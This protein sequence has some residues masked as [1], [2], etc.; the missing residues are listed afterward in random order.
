MIGPAVTH[1]VESTVFAT[2]AALLLRALRVRKPSVRHAAWLLAAIK[3]A[4]PA[5][6]FT[7]LGGNI[8]AL[9]PQ[10][11]PIAWSGSAVLLAHVSTLPAAATVVILSSEKPPLEA[12]LLS[13]WLAGAIFATGVWLRRWSGRPFQTVSAPAAEAAILHRLRILA[14]VRRAVTLRHFTDLT[15]PGLTGIRKPVICIPETLA[16][17]LEPA[18]FESVLLHELAHVRRWD[19]LGSAVVHAIACVF[20]FYPPTWWIERKI[21]LEAERACDQLVVGWGAP[22]ESYAAG[23]LKVCRLQIAAP[24]AGVSGIGSNL[25]ERIEW[26]MSKRIGQ[27]GGFLGSV[28]IA[29]LAAAM[30]VAPFTVGFIARPMLAV[31]SEPVLQ[32]PASIAPEP[33]P[34]PAVSALRT[35]Q[36][37][38]A[39]PFAM[40]ARV[41][42]LDPK[43]PQVWCAY[44]SV[45]YPEGTVGH[46]GR[47]DRMCI[48]DANGDP[49]WVIAET[50]GRPRAGE[51]VDLWAV[52]Q[53]PAGLPLCKVKGSASASE[54]ACESGPVPLGVVVPSDR[55]DRLVCDKWS[56]RNSAGWRPAIQGKDYQ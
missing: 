32:S 4:L 41:T 43:P 42:Q 37:R 13:L 45:F 29:I 8:R 31:R 44:M 23:I 21:A 6:L 52:R 14:G 35:P 46:M 50:A 3:F 19:N 22:G 34:R 18:E 2:L 5:F 51:I 27:P 15:A 20:W 56:T 26:I 36:K 25:S 7:G 16:S 24:L 53:E 30:T 10:P 47:S 1:L 9:M 38:K 49:M 17:E 12:A 40:A 54:C 33:A 39:R 11:I 28:A 55:G 48:G